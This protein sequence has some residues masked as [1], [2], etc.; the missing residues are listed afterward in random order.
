MGILAPMLAQF[1][2]SDAQIGV[3]IVLDRHGALLL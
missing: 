3:Q 2:F 1:V